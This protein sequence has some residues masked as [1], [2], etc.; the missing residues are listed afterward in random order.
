LFV[1]VGGIALGQ[2]TITVRRRPAAGPSLYLPLNPFQL[3][4]QAV[5][6]GVDAEAGKQVAELQQQ[7]QAERQ[8]HWAQIE[9]EMNEAYTAKLLETFD[10]E[11]RAQFEK[12]LEIA[13]A[14]HNA[15]AQAKVDF[16]AIW[17]A[18]FD[19]PPPSYVPAQIQGILYGLPSLTPEQR[20]EISRA[21]LG[22][23]RQEYAARYKQD[24]DRQ[25]IV[26]PA[27]RTD[28]EAWALYSKRLT[29]VSAAITADLEAKYQAALR[30][31]LPEDVRPGYDALLVAVAAYQ[32]AVGAASQAAEAALAEVLPPERIE[33]MRGRGNW[34]Q[35]YGTST[36]QIRA[37][38]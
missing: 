22:N 38:Q 35:G 27:A 18:T 17:A 1:V 32:K 7:Y 15:L 11:T 21:T 30:E 36:M 26:Q 2:E 5:E 31:G 23:Y 9:K 3:A 19:T 8:E 4:R 6:I 28:R 10:E 34:G 16:D 13:R 24:I 37:G 25:G 33:R 20:A 12:V 29:E 14:Y